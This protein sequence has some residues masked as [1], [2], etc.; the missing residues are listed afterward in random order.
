MNKATTLFVGFVAALLVVTLT[1]GAVAAQPT[2][3]EQTTHEQMQQEN[4][5][6]TPT[7]TPT[8]TQTPTQDADKERCEVDRAPPVEDYDIFR[9][10]PVADT[11]DPAEITVSADI[12]SY[13][14]CPVVIE[15]EIDA[16]DG[17]WF[18]GVDTS[19]VQA[20]TAG[21]VEM[22]ATA[23]PS[24]TGRMEATAKVGNQIEGVDEVDFT[25]SL[26]AYPEGYR[27]ERRYRVELT[28]LTKNIAIESNEPVPDGGVESGS[29][30]GDGPGGSDGG[31]DSGGSDGG[32]DSGGSGG[33][34]DPGGEGESL[35]DKIV[36]NG[37]VVALVAIVGIVAI[38]G[39]KTETGK[40]I[41]KRFKK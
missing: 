5:T 10:D 31:D 30:S 21:A 17:T 9:K 34:D 6:E 12:K 24:A 2:F 26:V 15:L 41:I 4:E 40:T 36:E 16:P 1:Q 27:E 23:Y 11:N 18:K 3:Q 39:G 25:A 14:S 7:P 35:W 38:A 20:G 29:D 37:T 33:G 8:P 22:T 13:Y 32:D 28:E 19:G